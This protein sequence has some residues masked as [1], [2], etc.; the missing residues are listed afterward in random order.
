MCVGEPRQQKGLPVKTAQRKSR[1]LISL[2]WI[3]HLANEKH[4]V[5][6]RQRVGVM[7]GKGD[8][9]AKEK[10]PGELRNN[11]AILEEQPGATGGKKKK[12]ND[13]NLIC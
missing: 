11:E 13:M 5:A 1:S 3:P 12:V 9:R 4:H 2:Y 6:G 7:E 10:V 8:G